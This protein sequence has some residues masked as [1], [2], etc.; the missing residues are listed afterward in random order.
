MNNQKKRGFSLVEVMVLFTVLAVAMAAMLPVITKKS[1]AVP[2]KVSHGVY[3]C[4]A[5]GNGRYLQETYNSFRRLRSDEVT[6]C[7]FHTPTANMYK[8]DLYGAGAGGTKYAAYQAEQDKVRTATLG[9]DQIAAYAK[10]GGSLV[11]VPEDFSRSDMPFTLSNDDLR[12]SL[13]NLVIITS[14]YTADAEQGGTAK[15]Q[16]SSPSRATCLAAIRG[17]DKSTDLSKQYNGDTGYTYTDNRNKAFQEY[18]AALK[19]L[20]DRYQSYKNNRKMWEDATENFRQQVAELEEQKRPWQER[21][22]ETV[23][24]LTNIGDAKEQIHLFKTAMDSVSNSARYIINGNGTAETSYNNIKNKLSKSIEVGY[25]LKSIQS[26]TYPYYYYPDKNSESFRHM[27]VSGNFNSDDLYRSIYTKYEQMRIAV[28]NIEMILE[29]PGSEINEMVIYDYISPIRAWAEDCSGSAAAIYNSADR[30]YKDIETYRDNLQYKVNKYQVQIAGINENIQGNETEMALLDKAWEKEESGLRADIKTKNDAYNEAE[31]AL[32]DR[33]TSTSDNGQ[34]VGKYARPGAYNEKSMLRYDDDGYTIAH[35]NDYCKA[36]YPEYYAQHNDP[37]LYFSDVEL[38]AMQR[39]GE[40]GKGT[41][42]QIHYTL[43]SAKQGSTYPVEEL[44]KQRYPNTPTNRKFYDGDTFQ[45]PYIKYIG[46]LFEN[47]DGW[48]YAPAICQEGKAANPDNCHL[49]TVEKPAINHDK[50]AGNE[51]IR[52]TNAGSGRWTIEAQKGQDVVPVQG[53]HVPDLDIGPF[54][55]EGS[56][57][58]PGYEHAKG[59][60]GGIVGYDENSETYSEGQA[61]NAGPNDPQYSNKSYA[62]TVFL[63]EG[64]SQA[65]KGADAKGDGSFKTRMSLPDTLAAA[66]TTYEVTA[67]DVNKKQQPKITMSA[68]MWKKTYS[69]GQPGSAG[70]HVH[71]KTP[72][73]GTRCEFTLPKGGA[74]YDYMLELKEAQKVHPT[75]PGSQAQY[76]E[77]KQREYQYGDR[78]KGENTPLREQPRT[79]IITCYDKEGT[80]VFEKIAKGGLYNFTPSAFGNAFIWNKNISEK[81]VEI[82]SDTRFAEAQK[83]SRWSKI[84]H[85]KD[86]ISNYFIMRPLN[87]NSSPGASYNVGD[88]GS[89]TVLHDKCTAPKG[90]YAYKVY[91]LISTNGGAWTQEELS[92][93]SRENAQGLSQ[94]KDGVD[95]YRDNVGSFKDEDAPRDHIREFDVNETDS[96]AVG[97]MTDAEKALYVIDDPTPAGGAAVVITW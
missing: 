9:M 18:K 94:E 62:Y 77:N 33:Y 75:K 34:Y 74:M 31:K 28:Q 7:T 90:Q 19:K 82:S 53:F 66:A 26:A 2:R 92:D 87:G 35:I 65:K 85:I 20:N 79:A 39:G 96:N 49:G 51:S 58:Y 21:L 13:N 55:P 42:A 97:Y 89:S 61:G 64:M 17:A 27:S 45:Y 60:E 70:Q 15:L 84:F 48:G 10:N 41:Y 69:L 63:N 71:V 16:Y 36:A 23:T 80:Q 29:D 93:R 46:N 54:A 83:R 67:S 43:K 12:A 57:A 38:T 24:A 76:M 4:I 50:D 44:V 30:I 91:Y 47:I 56:Y 6:Q 81:R 72:T 11:Y 22:D 68:D 25:G 78:I 37:A 86:K 59:G 14:V 8:V 73:L 1:K 40:E 3:R 95:C 32:S 52:R 88:G 5:L